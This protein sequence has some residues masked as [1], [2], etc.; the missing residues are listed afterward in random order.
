MTG[1]NNRMKEVKGNELSYIFSLKETVSCTYNIIQVSV[2][3][4][5]YIE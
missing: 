5:F 1:L 3:T 4:T 2:S